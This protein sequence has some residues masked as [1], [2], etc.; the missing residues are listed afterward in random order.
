[1]LDIIRAAL[2]S[3]DLVT[4]AATLNGIGLPTA[5]ESVYLALYEV[6][7]VDFNDG[8][9]TLITDETVEVLE[10]DELASRISEARS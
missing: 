5:Y 7:L 9:W 8:H 2:R 4:V 10:D 6:G 3:R 1:M